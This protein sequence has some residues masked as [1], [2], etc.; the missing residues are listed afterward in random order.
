MQVHL[1]YFQFHRSTTQQYQ[2]GLRPSVWAEIL[3]DNAGW[4]QTLQLEND[5]V[6]L[7]D[8]MP[9]HNLPKL[10]Q[11]LLPT[12]CPAVMHRVLPPSL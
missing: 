11:P 6:P 12:Q 9:R 5:H 1:V 4:P 8:S 3:V 7:R 10:A 2:L